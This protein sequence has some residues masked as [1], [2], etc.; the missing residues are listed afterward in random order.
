MK[1]LITISLFIFWA[2][3]VAI[4]TAELVF[5]QN[6][7]N[8]FTTNSSDNNSLTASSTNDQNMNSTTNQSSRG[9]SLS[10]SEIAKHSVPS[11]CWLLI[12]NK[13]YNVSSFITAHPGGSKTIIPNCGKDSTQAYN[14][15]G[16]NGSHSSNANTMLRDYYI[17]DFNQQTSQQQI[18]QS[19]QNTN[20]VTPP[21]GG[22]DE[23]E[24]DD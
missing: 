14:T 4:L 13:V 20:M 9:I 2:I 23:E 17:G 3:V 1:K 6:N 5:Y 11:D 7:K 12:N 16:G 22:E 24:D 8:I 15:K 19:V 18:Q 21:A 10:L